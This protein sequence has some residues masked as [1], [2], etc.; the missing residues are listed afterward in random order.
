MGGGLEKNCSELSSP[1]AN[2]TYVGPHPSGVPI[3]HLEDEE[4]VVVEVDALSAQQSRHDL[5]LRAPAVDRVE[6]GVV[7]EGGARY[8]Q[9]AVRHHLKVVVP[10]RRSGVDEHD[11]L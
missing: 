7:S 9:L 6:G 3:T 8:N 11:W 10:L 4:A 5:E 1:S 2:H